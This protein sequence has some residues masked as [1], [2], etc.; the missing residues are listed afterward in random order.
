M[1]TMSFIYPY[2]KQSDEEKIF[3]F[4][5]SLLWDRRFLNRWRNNYDVS[6]PI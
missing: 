6:W 1:N 4:Y 2:E 5:L 3:S